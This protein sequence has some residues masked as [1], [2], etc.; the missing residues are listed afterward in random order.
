MTETPKPG[1][2]AEAVARVDDGN[3][4]ALYTDESDDPACE[5]TAQVRRLY[6]ESNAPVREIARRVGVSERTLYKYVEKG[7]WTR[8]R[9]TASDDA[10]R[11][12]RA[13]VTNACARPA[14]ES[15]S[16][17]ACS[18]RPLWPMAMPRS[19]R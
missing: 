11:I 4:E 17:A 19:M 13:G 18:A 2:A 9:V 7:A 15:P 12:A 14:A 10:S 3:S 6:E 16:A 5:L 1:G 8:R